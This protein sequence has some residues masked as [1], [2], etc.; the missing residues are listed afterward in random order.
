VKAWIG[1]WRK[2]IGERISARGYRSLTQFMDEHPTKSFLELARDLGEAIAAE[3]L[4]RMYRA[5]ATGDPLAFLRFARSCLVRR[6]R[7]LMPAGWGDAKGEVG[8]VYACW[9]G[10]VG[11]DHDA[12]AERVY[13]M[14]HVLAP[15]G[16]LPDGPDD[17]VIEEAF[18]RWSS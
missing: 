9:T 17:P 1:D 15:E 2:R 10:D 18:K 3:Q 14:M 16:W 7:W 8:R 5:E 11:E 12:A 4:I 13:D 6:V